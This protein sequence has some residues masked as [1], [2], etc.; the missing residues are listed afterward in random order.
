MFILNRRNF[1][2]AA[3]AAA[4]TPTLAR[5]ALASS[6]VFTAG[7]EGALVDSVVVMGEERAV[8]V[9]AQF[10]APAAAALA[11]VIEASGRTLE[12]VFITHYHPDHVL[13]L[14]VILKRF[15]DAKAVAHPKV[16]ALI[17]QYAPGM[18]AGF[19]KDA[20]AGVFAERAV[21]PDA[22]EADHLM[23][24]GERIEILDPMH[25]DTDL[26]TA[27][28]IPSLDT[29]VATDFAYADT[30]LWVAENLEPEQIDTWRKNTETLEAIGASTVIPGHRKPESANDATVFA[31]TRAYLDRWAAARAEA[32]SADELK[33]ALLAGNEELGFALAVERAAMAAFPEG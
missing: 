5:A 13:G 11:D 31:K 4:L 16:Q 22:L 2:A 15:P 1:L 10:V 17:E 26:I 3:S 25:G 27:V 29:L 30:H 32:K 24:E 7:P 28:H 8:L 33:A 6:E 9:D 18:L 20:P 14:D 19:S 21:I 12:T 23:L